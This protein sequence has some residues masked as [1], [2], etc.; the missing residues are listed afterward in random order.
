MPVTTRSQQIRHVSGA[1][2]KAPINLKFDPAK[3]Q[4]VNLS[5]QCRSRITI[6]Y[7]VA[8]TYTDTLPLLPTGYVWRIRGTIIS[9]GGGG[10]GGSGGVFI[11]IGVPPLNGSGG[12]TNSTVFSIPFFVDFPS[13]ALVTSVVG[14]G[15]AGGAGG[16]FNFAGAMG[17]TGSVTSIVCN[18]ISLLS[19]PVIG[20]M[21]GI[22]MVGSSIG[23]V[24]GIGPGSSGS[25]G[26]GGIGLLAGSPGL[27]GTDGRVVFTATPFQI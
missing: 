5:C 15:G 27:N 13:G 19:P 24:G 8:G 2:K 11:G 20:G 4:V 17:G 26:N 18:S 7:T 22:P 6:D 23:E 14:A 9:G 1:G 16:Q 10:G 21:G 3:Q 12:K 25:G